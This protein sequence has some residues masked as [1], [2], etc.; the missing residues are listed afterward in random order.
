MGAGPHNISRNATS[1]GSTT[2]VV[3]K[4]QSQVAKS[5]T[6]TKKLESQQQSIYENIRPGKRTDQQNINYKGLLGHYAKAI[7]D[8]KEEGES[9]VPPPELNQTITQGFKWLSENGG[10]EVNQKFHETSVDVQNALKAFEKDEASPISDKTPEAPVDKASE[11][12]QTEPFIMGNAV[13]G[14][15][16]EVSPFLDSPFPAPVQEDDGKIDLPEGLQLPGVTGDNSSVGSSNISTF[17]SQDTSPDSPFHIPLP[18][19]VLPGLNTGN[20]LTP[21]LTAEQPSVVNQSNSNNFMS[22]SP[23]G[24]QQS[25]S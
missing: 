20:L 4:L 3:S 10:E 2:D 7:R 24:I 21:G 9:T 22:I 1:L 18:S 15:D 13:S 6:S 11:K 19:Q 17:S 23:N 14:S 12:D 5:D 25:G 16:E 8:K